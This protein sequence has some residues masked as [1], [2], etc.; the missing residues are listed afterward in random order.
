MKILP[1]KLSYSLS[2]PHKLSTLKNLLS[3]PT[4]MRMMT[5]MRMVRMMKI[6]KKRRQ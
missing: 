3:R 4:I 5:M 6:K 2:Q 1:N